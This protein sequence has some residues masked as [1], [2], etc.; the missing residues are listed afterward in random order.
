MVLR[1]QRH[2]AADG[3]AGALHHERQRYSMGLTSKV[4]FTLSRW[5]GRL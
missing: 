2:F 3:L 1:R 4:D 5:S